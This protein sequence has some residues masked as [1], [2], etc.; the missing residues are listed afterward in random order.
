MFGRNPWR[1]LLA[2]GLIG[3]LVGATL[4]ESGRVANPSPHLVAIRDAAH[5]DAVLAS[6]RVVLA[7]FYADWCGPCRQ[8]KPTMHDLA[9][10][11]H[12]RA[13]VAAVDVDR[14]RDVAVAHHVAGIP[15]VRVFVDGRPRQAWVGG[16]DRAV[17]AAALEA[18]IVNG[19]AR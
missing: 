12:G 14:C 1:G 2:G 16:Q 8:L 18:A 9:D 15:D 5:F 13:V 6:N 4:G 17:Y 10:A 11:F 3:L 7:D 19:D